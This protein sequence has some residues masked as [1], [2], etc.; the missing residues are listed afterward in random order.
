LQEQA[1]AADAGAAAGM[2]GLAGLDMEGL[3]MAKMMEMMKDPETMKAMEQMGDQ[4]AGAMDGLSK[5]SPEELMQQ[6]EE[7]MKMLT[8]GDMVEALLGNKNDILKELESAGTVPPEE[9]AKFKADPAY[10]ELKMRE[11]FSQMEDIF[12]DPEM[13]KTMTDAM[14]GMQEM[15]GDPDAL[16]SLMGEALADDDKIEEARLELLRGDNPALSAMFDNAEMQEILK[17]P[18]KFRDQVKEG[19]K[20]MM[21]MGDEL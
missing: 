16:A 17:D 13:M 12:K 7:A 4:F 20:G 1:V 14:S 2:G 6:M 19:Q 11:S 15:M 5:M 10:F 18:I 3:D 9:L 8:D 21:G